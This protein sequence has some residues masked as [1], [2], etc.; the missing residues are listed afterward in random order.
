MASTPKFISNNPYLIG[1][2]LL[3]TSS[4]AILLNLVNTQGKEGKERCMSI[5]VY[6]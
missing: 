6:T 1:I 2:I 3:H 4:E 5:T